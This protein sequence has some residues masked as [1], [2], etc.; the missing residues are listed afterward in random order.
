FHLLWVLVV[1]CGW[2]SSAISQTR[3]PIPS[4]DRDQHVYVVDVP[5]Q[6]GPLRD[7]ITR[8]ERTSPQTYYVVVVRSTGPGRSATRDYLDSLVEQWKSQARRQNATFDTKRSVV[9]VL[10]IE[11]REIIVLG[12]EELQE[13]FGFRDPYIERDLLQPHFYPY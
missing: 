12:G 11:K 2:T 1:L 10:A 7:D 3:P 13:Q 9:I 5:D 4:F 8:L 6:F